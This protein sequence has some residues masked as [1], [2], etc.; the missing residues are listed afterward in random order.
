MADPSRSI[1]W[2]M[3]NLKTSC[4]IERKQEFSR[5]ASGK[6]WK[7]KP[8]SEKTTKIP[9]EWYHNVFDGI[10]FFRGLGGSERVEYNYTY[11]GYLPTQLTSISPDQERKIVRRY[12]ILDNEETARNIY[13]LEWEDKSA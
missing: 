2:H 9:A 7:S 1:R 8:D 5:T 13:H 3:S 4:I 12:W 11:A 6:S 10:P